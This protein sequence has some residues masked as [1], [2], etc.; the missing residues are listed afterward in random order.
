MTTALIAAAHA[1]IVSSRGG[2]QGRPIVGFP[3]N[4]LDVNVLLREE[5]K[6]PKITL[7]NKIFFIIAILNFLTLQFIPFN[8]CFAH[9]DLKNGQFQ[10]KLNES[11]FKRVWLNELVQSYP[12]KP[13]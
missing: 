6:R 1:A 7:C 9:F 4:A 5:T 11:Q 8:V 10:I 2:D 13:N 12:V 3:M